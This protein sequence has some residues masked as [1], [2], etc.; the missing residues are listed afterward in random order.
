MSIIGVHYPRSK[1]GG[2]PGIRP[3]VDVCCP[4]IPSLPGELLDVEPIALEVV[5]L[6][7][8]P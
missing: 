2:D 4:M 7:D 8:E 3:M 1:V 5:S 6:N